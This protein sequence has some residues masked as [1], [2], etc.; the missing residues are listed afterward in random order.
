MIVNI[1]ELSFTCIIGILDFERKK[2]Q[3]VI[4]DIKF[5]Y[6]YKENEFVNYAEVAQIV[7]EMMKKNKYF[8]IEEAILDITP[9][10]KKTFPK[11]L[12]CNLKITKPSILPDCKV[13]VELKS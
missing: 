9:N 7:K 4:V 5:E 8:L 13:S 2:E 10:L 11:I 3:D 12:W 1:K 6:N